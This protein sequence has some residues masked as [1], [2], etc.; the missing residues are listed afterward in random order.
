MCLFQLGCGSGASSNIGVSKTVSLGSVTTIPLLGDTRALTSMVV[1]NNAG[2]GVWLVATTII[3]DGVTTP[4]GQSEWADV[5][6]C[7]Y[8]APNA[9]CQVIITP[10]RVSGSFVIKLRFIDEHGQSYTGTQ[11]ISYSTTYANQDHGFIYFTPTHFPINQGNYTIALPVVLI[12]D[13]SELYVS[14]QGLAG[15]QTSIECP[16]NSYIAGTMCTVYIN[17]NT[18]TSAKPM[19]QITGKI[20]DI[21]KQVLVNRLSIPL[22]LVNIMAGH[23]LVSVPNIQATAGSATT[24]T[25][26]NN[27][28]ATVTGI[29]YNGITP[30]TATTS[31][32]TC[33]TTLAAGSSC[34]FKVSVG[35]V[36]SSG[37]G[38]VIILYSNG[39]GQSES[40]AFFVYYFPVSTSPGLTLTTTGW[41]VGTLA[42]SVNYQGILITN[43]GTATLDDLHFSNVTDQVASLGYGGVG[44]SCVYGQSL[45][46][47]ASCLL[48]IYYTPNAAQA[49]SAS[50]F[51]NVSATGEYKDLAGNLNTTTSNNLIVPYSAEA[52]AANMS[53]YI[54]AGDYGA[55]TANLSSALISGTTGWTVRNNTP[56]VGSA[57]T[58]ARM[59]HNGAL[60][61]MGS[62]GTPV[63][64]AGRIYQADNGMIWESASANGLANSPPTG[65]SVS[66]LT[67]D[68]TNGYLVTVTS[69]I[70]YS[71][72]ALNKLATSWRTPFVAFGTTP[73]VDLFN[74]FNGTQ[75]SY[76]APQNTATQN[77]QIAVSQTPI[78]A[79]S[80]ANP[81]GVVTAYTYTYML[82]DGINFCLIQSTASAKAVCT[83]AASFIP[84]S[85]W[86]Q[87]PVAIGSQ[88]VTRFTNNGN[89]SYVAL[90]TTSPFAL[91]TTTS[92]LT[93]PAWSSA[94]GL[95]SALSWV[96]YGGGKYIGITSATPGTIWTSPTGS[97]WSN[98]VLGTANSPINKSY[99]FV[100]HDGNNY[101][102][103]GALVLR[104]SPD[105]IN[106]SNAGIRSLTY[107]YNGITR[108]YLAAG[109][110]GAIVRSTNLTSWSTVNSGI[111]AQINQIACFNSNN[112][113]AVANG[114]AILFSGD[115]AGATWSPET[116]G[117]TTNL[118]SVVC[119][120]AA[121]VVVGDNGVILTQSSL[122]NI[123]QLQTVGSGLRNLNSVTFSK[124]YNRY[125]AVGDAGVIYTSS[126]GLTWSSQS[127][128]TTNNLIAV[129]C[130]T[131][132]DIGCMAVGDVIGTPAAGTVLTS[133]SGKLWTVQATST[134]S[135]LAIDFYNGNWVV[136]QTS[137]AAGGTIRSAA[138]T[139]PVALSA[140]KTS[141]ISRSAAMNFN[142]VLA[143]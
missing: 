135:N 97:T 2:T 140:T 74:F 63:A 81:T 65:A 75:W 83:P 114:G 116:S 121:C 139:L 34:T 27:G 8:I 69:A 26:F 28:N 43:T 138:D 64:N 102:A 52:P 130:A 99:T 61:V 54:V 60:Q 107:L 14:L 1:N 59:T 7:N 49:F 23:L 71:T 103:G 96:A 134:G 51:I 62:G 84:T 18:Q 44:Q 110:A 55:I 39:S 136:A 38:S 6:G 105:G 92:P 86:T 53:N 131:G 21:G 106:W 10:P 32:G 141:G 16:G 5:T 90:V 132:S 56:F 89:S 123:W 3:K 128:G 98:Q 109:T 19:L 17:Y 20:A 111:N 70:L 129:K 13:Y 11:I 142:T 35:Q 30:I 24:V 4:S 122:S 31:G 68:S 124:E 66:G 57:T 143:Y 9:H 104:V 91:Y 118:N 29:T 58:V 133:L 77:R 93:S 73:P 137:P 50:T 40:T 45:V 25:M 36:S 125:V 120:F 119:G 113:L 79:W 41:L 88:T 42:N 37:S 87:N 78:S 112:C 12:S 115:G 67:Y 94:T 48:L 22:D 85:A 108:T 101:W 117:T 95:S 76:F 15:A 126:D 47:D 80:A 127:S 46:P 100:Y 82:Y 72:A 33:G